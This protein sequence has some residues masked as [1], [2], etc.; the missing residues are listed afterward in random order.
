MQL[1][2]ASSATY[3]VFVPALWWAAW[4]EHLTVNSSEVED[5]AADLR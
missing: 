4:A 2:L 1:G 3:A 5:V